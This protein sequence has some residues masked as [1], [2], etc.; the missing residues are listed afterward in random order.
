M[1]WNETFLINTDLNDY[2]D[3]D[4]DDDDDDE[5]NEKQTTKQ[6]MYTMYIIISIKSTR[7]I[8]TAINVMIHMI[9]GN[10]ISLLRTHCFCFR[11]DNWCRLWREGTEYKVQVDRCGC[12]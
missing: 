7:D 12:T 4:D 6:L 11:G 2:D 1:N 3:D 10:T 8:L 9:W 5:F